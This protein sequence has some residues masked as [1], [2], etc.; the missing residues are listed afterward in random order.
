MY[1]ETFVLTLVLYDFQADTRDQFRSD[2]NK[3]FTTNI[4]VLGCSFTYVFLTTLSP[5]YKCQKVQKKIS[6][7]S[8]FKKNPCCA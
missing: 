4:N 6:F 3:V 2:H 1:S 7:K 5:N 8:A